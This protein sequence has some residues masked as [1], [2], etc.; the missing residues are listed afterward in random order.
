ML[1]GITST[2][3]DDSTPLIIYRLAG[4]KDKGQ[5]GQ[6]LTNGTKAQNYRC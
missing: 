3:L 6:D 4:M 1:G 5:G 2:C